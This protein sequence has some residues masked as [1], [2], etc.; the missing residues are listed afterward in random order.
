MGDERTR[1]KAGTPEFEAF[2][3]RVAL[4]DA[5]K[6]ALQARAAEII[7]DVRGHYFD[8]QFTPRDLLSDLGSMSR[9]IPLA[10]GEFLEQDPSAVIAAM[11]RGE[12]VPASEVLHI[13]GS[14]SR[15]WYCGGMRLYR[16][17]G[18]RVSANEPCPIGND[19]TPVTVEVNAPSGF[20]VIGDVV[21]DAFFVRGN[22]HALYRSVRDRRG[23]ATAFARNGCLCL[24]ACA[25]CRGNSGIG[26]YRTAGEV[27]QRSLGIISCADDPHASA[28]ELEMLARHQPEQ[29]AWFSTRNLFAVA[30]RDEHLRRGGSLEDVKVVQVE[31]GVYRCIVF[32]HDPHHDTTFDGRHVQIEWV[33]PPDPVR[34]FA[35]EERAFHLTAGQVLWRHQQERPD[36]SPAHVMDL[37]FRATA[38]EDWHRNGF[39]D[40]SC[41]GSMKD[42]EAEIPTFEGELPVIHLQ[43]EGF[44]HSALVRAARGELPLNPSFARLARQLLTAIAL[45]GLDVEIF[46]PHYHGEDDIEGCLAARRRAIIETAKDALA[47]LNELYPPA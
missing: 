25:N 17:D 40:L 9:S 13:G 15:C 39:C 34:D 23:F 7:W 8:P 2:R 27:G 33:R 19:R 46:R 20:L 35:A 3:A 36:H 28:Q 41:D 12:S 4:W 24:P 14:D 6:K 43:Q 32:C 26:L 29:L 1:P 22:R 5:F 44:S 16:F 30:D 21:K 31:P 18:A 37:M 42:P 10:D 47:R 38:R 45:H 11:G